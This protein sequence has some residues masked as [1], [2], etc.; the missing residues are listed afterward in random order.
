MRRFDNDA[1]KSLSRRTFPF[2]RLLEPVVARP[3]EC[4]TPVGLLCVAG[5][6]Q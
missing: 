2:G 1:L 5:H 6:D 4:W 3:G